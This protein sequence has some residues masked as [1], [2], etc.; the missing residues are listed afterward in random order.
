MSDQKNVFN[1][2]APKIPAE[3]VKSKRVGIGLTSREAAQ[4]AGI[5]HRTWQRFENGALEMPLGVWERFL[6]NLEK[7]PLPAKSETP[8]L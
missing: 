2:T 7:N 3:I 8:S 4:I 5:N 6:L 1:L